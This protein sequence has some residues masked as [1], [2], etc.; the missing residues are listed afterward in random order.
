[1]PCSCVSGVTK[2]S[3]TLP[4]ISVK[5][6]HIVHAGPSLQV[7]T[8][9]RPGALTYSQGPENDACTVDLVD[10]AVAG[11]IALVMTGHGAVPNCLLSNKI[12]NAQAAG[13]VGVIL[14][15][16]NNSTAY[17]TAT[18]VGVKIPSCNILRVR[19]C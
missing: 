6:H 1:M 4:A 13:A 19:P 18:I 3:H 16:A 11:K 12:Q 14:Y 2:K 5:K 10:P 15:N 9:A 17:F 8:A 7:V